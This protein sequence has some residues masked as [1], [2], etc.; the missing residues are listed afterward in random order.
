MGASVETT[1][2]LFNRAA[3]FLNIDKTGP[4]GGN[5]VRNIKRAGTCG[6]EEGKICPSPF[7]PGF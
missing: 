3:A 5:F 1:V 6:G 2:R 4:R 7:C